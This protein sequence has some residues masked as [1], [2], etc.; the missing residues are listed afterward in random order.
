MRRLAAGMLALF[1]SAGVLF[2]EPGTA[3]SPPTAPPPIDPINVLLRLVG[4]TL[5]TLVVCGGLIWWVRRA[6]A[7]KMAKA[8]GG[9]RMVLDGQLLLDGKSKVTLIRVDGKP[10]VVTTDST[11]LRS[12]VPLQERFDTVLD[13]EVA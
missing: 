11:G 9:G 4:L 2:A 7:G 3:Y 12:I 6:G 13:D 1:L 8:N 10:V 5:L